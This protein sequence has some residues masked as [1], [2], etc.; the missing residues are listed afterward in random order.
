MELL[1]FIFAG[2]CWTVASTGGFSAKL[3]IEGKTKTLKRLSLLHLVVG[4]HNKTD[5]DGGLRNLKHLKKFM[6]EEGA[7]LAEDCRCTDP[8]SEQK[9]KG[10]GRKSDTPAPVLC[11]DKKTVTRIC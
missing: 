8:I 5:D 2:I 7:V 9:K 1:I 3:K 6:E 4:L 11:T 10:R